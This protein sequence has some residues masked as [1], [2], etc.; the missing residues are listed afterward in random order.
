MLL[1]ELLF[2]LEYKLLYVDCDC[3]ISRPFC[4]SRNVT[5]GGLFVCL[6]GRSTDGALYINEAINAGAAA[7]VSQKVRDG[8]PTVV[9]RDTRYALAVIWNNFFGRPGEK[10]RLYG[11]TGTNGKT[12][13]AHFLASCLRADSRRVGTIGTL[14]CFAMGERISCTGSEIKG[15]AAA[16]T[17]PDPEYLYGT[18]AEFR[19]RGITDVVMEVSSHAICQRKVDCLSFCVGIFTNLSPE[20]LDYHADM[21]EY[22]RVKASFVARCAIRVV[23]TDDPW[24]SRFSA[25]VPS[26]R[27]GME[28]IGDIKIGNGGVSYTF[29][30]ER[31]RS[32][33]GGEF[34]VY[35][36]LLAYRAALLC[37][38]SPKNAAA[39]IAS[40]GEVRGR[41]ERAVRAE[42]EGFDVIIDY[43]HTPAALE[44]VLRHLK[45]GARGKLICVFGCGGDR[46]PKKRPEMGR[47]AEIYSDAVIVTSDNS[48]GESPLAIIRDIIGGM[49]LSCSVVIPDRREAIFAAVSMASEGDT[50]LLAGKGHESYEIRGERVLDFDE[51]EIVKEAVRLKNGN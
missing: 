18:L 41:L 40:A 23:N 8:V 11:I 3:Q 19:S 49:V 28:S 48:R 42:D 51:R 47:I 39:G 21:E 35:N 37:G 7:V 22:F 50:V 25:A 32:S 33:V 46:D 4:D 14:G 34:T 43:A 6:E 26:F 15:A 9:V 12:S 30:G 17:T 24:G 13:T 5:E 10:M 27:T 31:I 38:V 2:G 36:T 16:M 44:S 45:K 1:K 29:E 20:H